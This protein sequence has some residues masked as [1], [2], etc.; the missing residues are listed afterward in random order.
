MPFLLTV[1]LECVLR[2][3]FELSA[4]TDV[5]HSVTDVV[6]SRGSLTLGALVRLEVTAR[7]VNL[8]F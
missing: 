1:Q 5:D 6:L 2:V 8:S 7:H 4:A 3:A